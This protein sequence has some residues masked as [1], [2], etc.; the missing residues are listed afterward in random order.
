MAHNTVLNCEVDGQGLR[1]A[2]FNYFCVAHFSQVPDL[3]SLINEIIIN[4]KC[5]LY[6]NCSL[7]YQ[8][9]WNKFAVSNECHCIM[10]CVPQ[11]EVRPQDNQQKISWFS[12]SGYARAA[13]TQ[14]PLSSHQQ[15]DEHWIL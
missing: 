15:T 13:Q 6:T 3:H 1:S 9:G 10:E 12:L 11:M 5:A 8:L 2:P 14:Q 7:I 4:V